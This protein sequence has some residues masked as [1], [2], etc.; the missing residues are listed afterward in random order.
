LAERKELLE[1][2]EENLRQF[3]QSNR[4]WSVSTDP[5]LRIE[6]ARL[7][8]EIEIQSETHLLL[9]KQLE[10]ARLEARK[11]IP[12]VRILDAPSLP[13]IKSGP[14]RTL[15]VVI[16]SVLALAAMALYVFAE[17]IWT[18]MS[19]GDGRGKLKE[20]RRDLSQAVPSPSRALSIISRS[21]R[22][23]EQVTAND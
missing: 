7:E 23:R 15:T 17:H 14:G 6:M 8:R 10:L 5:N 2:A 1:S 9:T 20:L 19:G 13:T 16:A 21:N 11:D 18:Q 22:S 12:I 4:N 3:M